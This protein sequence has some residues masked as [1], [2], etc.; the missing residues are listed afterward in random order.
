MYSQDF[1]RS[2]RLSDQIR[3]EISAI[4]REEVKDPRLKGLTIIKVK[5][6]KDIK[7]AFIF[8]SASNSFSEIKLE[9]VFIGLDKA[10]GF[11][12]KLLG[13]RLKVKRIPELFFETDEINF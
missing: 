2:D 9:D 5:L 4:L 11:I 6:S 13:Q 10:K 3:T 8:F 12:R 1:S 7:Q